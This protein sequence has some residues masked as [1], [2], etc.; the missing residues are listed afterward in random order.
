[1]I[2]QQLIASEVLLNTGILSLKGI[3][4]GPKINIQLKDSTL[5]DIQSMMFYFGGSIKLFKLDAPVW[6]DDYVLVMN[7]KIESEGFVLAASY[8]F[9]S[10]IDFSNQISAFSS[11]SFYS[12]SGIA[13]QLVDN[14]YFLLP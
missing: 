13:L 8:F 5:K 4:G 11:D 1:M 9:N 10:E 2:N 3:K 6:F 7:Y 14:K 12:E